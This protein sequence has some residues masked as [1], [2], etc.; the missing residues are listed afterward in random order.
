MK[1]GFIFLVA[2]FS[3]LL[4]FAQD[5]Y[6]TQ[7]NTSKINTNPAFTGS[8][9]ALVLSSAATFHIPVK[10][11]YNQLFF[12]ADNYF[13]RLRGGLGITYS[14][15]SVSGG[16][17]ITSRINFIYAPHFE[18]F[19]HSL[20]LQPA[21]SVGYFERSIDWSK[22]TFGDMI[23]E[24][25]GFVY[26]THEMPVLSKKS[27]LDLSAG[28]LAY[29]G[30]FYGGF[31]VHHIT[32]PDEGLI[33]S[34][35]LPVRYTIHGGMN[36]IGGRILK[37]SLNAM[38][39]QQ[40]DF[41]MFLLGLTLQRKWLVFGA[42]IGNSKSYNLTIGLQNRFFKLSYSYCYINAPTN[43]NEIHFNW[44]IKHRKTSKVHSIRLI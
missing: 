9:S 31:A 24:R 35:P 36:L 18:L 32:Q 14:R 12:S 26:D 1:K 7:Y 30:C 10:E 20:V 44:F 5:N 17:L 34:S 15:E 37:L 40:Q 13:R 19:D 3:N 11:N 21:I 42:A 39:Q 22:L 28:I 8:D 41:S 33:G 23:D 29:Y 43:V 27:N 16:K 6:F 4:M 2:L 38:Y 25:N